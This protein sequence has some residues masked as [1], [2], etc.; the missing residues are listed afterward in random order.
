MHQQHIPED[1]M[2]KKTPK[3]ERLSGRDCE[4]QE[5]TLRREY[6]VKIERISAEN[7]M[8]RGKSFDL[9]KQKMTKESLRISGLTQKLGKNFINRHHI[10]PR[11][12]TFLINKILI[13]ERNSSGKKYTVR[14]EDLEKS[15]N[16]W[17]KTN[18]IVLKMQGR[19]EF[20]TLLQLYPRIRSYEKISR[21]LFT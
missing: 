21:K 10:A 18:S 2:R 12:S 5:P 15:Q 4:F 3:M 7:L 14:E 11:S 1:W 19:T 9:K 20:C 6:T 13:I 17:G 16:I 8:A